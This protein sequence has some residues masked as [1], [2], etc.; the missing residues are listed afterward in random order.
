MAAPDKALIQHGNRLSGCSFQP[1]TK[2]IVEV[3]A[4]PHLPAGIL[5]PYNDG[6]RAHLSPVSPIIYGARKS[7]EVAASPFSPSLY[8][9]KCLA[10]R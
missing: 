8:G 6:E 9:E 1:M 3:G 7:T 4:A 2:P 5:S 10:G